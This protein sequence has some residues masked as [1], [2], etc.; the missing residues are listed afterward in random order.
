VSDSVDSDLDQVQFRAVADET[1]E[2]LLRFFGDIRTARVFPR[3]KPL[4][5]QKLLSEPL[6]L[7]PQSPVRIVKEVEK[8]IIPNSSLLGSP[9]WFGFANATG[10][11]MSVFGDEIAA[12]INAN[13]GAWK[14][15]PAAT[16]LERVVIGWLAEMVG[17]GKDTGGLLVS[18]GMMANVIGLVTGLHDKAGY[19]IAAEG[20]QSEKR[21][22]KFLLYMSD[23]EGHSSIVKA[24][25]LLGLGKESVRLVKSNEDFT[26]NVESLDKSIERDARAGNNPFCVVAQ[27]GSINVGAVDPLRAIS[28]VCKKHDLWFHA[29]GAC[30]AF[31]RIIPRKA[32]LFDGLEL[33]DSVTLDPQKWLYVSYECG[34]VL[35]RD[36][37][38]LKDTF[39]L[40]APY[41]KGILPTDYAG[42][43]F[44]DYG[45]QM[46]RGFRALKVWMSIK[47]YGV[48]GYRRLLER[49]VA[50]IE[51]LDGLVRKSEEFEPM[52]KPV[53]QMYCFRFVP[54]A[55]RVMPESELSELNQKIA[56]STQL[57]GKAFLMTT[58]IR[59]KTAL[60]I[61]IT[62]HRTTKED[63]DLTFR[64]LR[65][66]GR[67]I[68]K[69]YA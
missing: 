10:T 28:R 14:P 25:Q 36:S 32:R 38:K 6:P 62:N 69:S 58:S 13:V 15:G 49:N 35:V 67:S 37:K 55:G 33:A 20:L 68:A 19:N 23:H 51:Y 44:W 3:K 53:L 1:T 11:M 46:A 56:D 7:K 41:L 18:G 34:C 29:D 66:I 26:M 48:E 4:D 39:A 22:G 63:V 61:S 21:R 64:T 8:K 65:R 17:F 54:R 60:R 30:G 50:L 59:G 52:C 24:A 40:R 45:P 31:G 12:A 2:M 5:I 27:V 42:I 9:R 57:T 47:Y 16:E 43:D